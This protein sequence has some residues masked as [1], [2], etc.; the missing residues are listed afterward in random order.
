MDNTLQLSRDH[1]PLGRT[2]LRCFPMAYGLWRFAGT[3]VKTARAKIETAL[4][5]GITLM[6]NADVYGCD[7][8]GAFGDA[9]VLLGKVL[10]DAPHLRDR[11]LIASK[12]GIDLGVPYDSSPEY[13]RQAVDA[14]LER[15]GI[16]CID[17][18]QIHRPDF[19]GHPER[20]AEVL[21]D[22]RAAGKIR[23]VGVSNYTPSQFRALQAWLPFPIATRQ[24]EFSCWV[25]DALRNGVL[26]QCL[27]YR[28]TPLVWSPLAG[29]RLAL[30][31]DEAARRPE[32][33]RLVDLIGTLDQ[34]A[35]SQG[36]HRSA[37][38]LAW[39]MAHP[40]GV[41]PIIGTQN[42]SRIQQSVAAFDVRLTRTEW[43]RILIA[44]QGEPLP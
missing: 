6:D 1:R 28:T 29:G 12:G 7:G 34:I 17:L 15:M 37:V 38:A 18:Y 40:S 33:A 24:P 11:M 2:S 10:R 21:V 20:M 5:V 9:E 3:D 36:T 16:E 43:N 19:L 31:A 8:G 35:E 26:D 42:L 32:G 39:T 27:E 22:L 25:H 14:S 23:E 30:D 44:A 41:I 13:L 4:E